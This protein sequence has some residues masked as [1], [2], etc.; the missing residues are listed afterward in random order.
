[1]GILQSLRAAFSG[2]SKKAVAPYQVTSNIA[3][4]ENYAGYESY[5][6]LVMSPSDYAAN[7]YRLHAPF[8]VERSKNRLVNN[9][10]VHLFDGDDRA[11]LN[12]PDS[13]LQRY[14]QQQTE[15]AVPSAHV[16]AHGVFVPSAYLPTRNFYHGW[17]QAYVPQEGMRVAISANSPRVLLSTP[18][19]SKQFVNEGKRAPLSLA[20]AHAP[21]RGN[22]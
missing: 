14:F 12:I 10:G 8:Q 15:L 2:P 4:Q 22:S 9:A 6:G 21:K 17:S 11:I 5:P 20:R 7:P 16:P 1:V 18:I 19:S 13:D 3:P